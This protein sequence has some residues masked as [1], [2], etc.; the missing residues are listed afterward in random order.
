MD[1][2]S[3]KEGTE[4]DREIERERGLG[5]YL[6]LLEVTFHPVVRE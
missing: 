3:H 4:R 2:A 6:C 5:A 1:V